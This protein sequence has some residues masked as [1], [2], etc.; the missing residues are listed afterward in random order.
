MEQPF[1]Y[2]GQRAIVSRRTAFLGGFGALALAA[3]VGFAV[4]LGDGLQWRLSPVT[5]RFYLASREHNALRSDC[6]HGSGQRS[7]AASLCTSS[8]PETGNRYDI[9]VWGDS[10]GDALFPAFAAI[11]ERHGLAARQAT[12]RGCP[13]LLGAER[14]D[15]G[16]RAKRFGTSSCEKY[17][18]GML[19]ELTKGQRPSLVILVARWS[20]YTETTTDVAG[21]RRIF[22]VD[23]ENQ[24]YDVETSRKVV[25]RALGRTIDA[26][27]A[28][29]I[30]V[31]LVGQS[32]EFFQDPNI[33]FVERAMLRRD[34]RDCLAQPRAIA[35][36]RLRVSEEILSKTANGRSGATY[37]SL[38]AILCDKEICRAMD[39][40]QPLYEDKNHLDLA[41]AFFVGR[42]L[43]ETPDL[44]RLFMPQSS[45]YA[46][47]HHFRN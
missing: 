38:A 31:L 42:A 30:P 40:D 34:A 35:D 32:P 13:P 47:I 9:V 7:T 17:N 23:D 2:S 37:V 39:N 4:Y 11:G 21:G 27:T 14:V 41:G 6:L 16:R 43:S 5:L 22:M 19:Q 24:N 8:A 25:S 12:K 15:E 10:H 26:V 28:L 36:Q 3:S 46:S 33:C 20:M 29:G 44:E 18:D 45:T 1:R